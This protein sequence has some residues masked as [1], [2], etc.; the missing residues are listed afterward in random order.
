ML[1]EISIEKLRAELKQIERL[2]KIRRDKSHREK[3]Q[4]ERLL[5]L[6]NFIKKFPDGK[7]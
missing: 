6:E 2:E 7:T 3:T 1:P 5:K 4:Y